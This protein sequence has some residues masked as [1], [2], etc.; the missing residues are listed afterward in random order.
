MK[1]KNHKNPNGG[2][3]YSI[4]Q[5]SCLFKNEKSLT[6]CHIYENVKETW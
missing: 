3:F 2:S 5:N 4:P 1:K 6:N